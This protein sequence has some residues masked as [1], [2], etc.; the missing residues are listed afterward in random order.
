MSHNGCHI[1]CHP[2]AW[3]E[4]PTCDTPAGCAGLAH[5][6]F[7]HDLGLAEHIG[8]RVTVMYLGRILAI[9]DKERL[10]VAPRHPYT[11]R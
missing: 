4:D 9:A 7:S 6:F 8:H 1:R 10:F 5:L 3:P 2:R 11:R